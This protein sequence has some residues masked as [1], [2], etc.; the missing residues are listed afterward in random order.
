MEWHFHN[1]ANH[2]HLQHNLRRGVHNLPIQVRKTSANSTAITGHPV[3]LRPHSNDSNAKH[4]H[5]CPRLLPCNSLQ[6]VGGKK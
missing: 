3:C 2:K 1:S 4:S 6:R 5:K